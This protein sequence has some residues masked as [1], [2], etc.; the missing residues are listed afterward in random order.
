[1]RLLT[2]HGPKGGVGKSTIACNF[3]VAARLDGIDA[4]GGGRRQRTVLRVHRRF[5]SVVGSS[6][7]GRCRWKVLCVRPRLTGNPSRSTVEFGNGE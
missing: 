6:L 4:G 1:M 3:L 5:S 7:M 2:I